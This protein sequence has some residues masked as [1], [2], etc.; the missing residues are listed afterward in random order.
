MCA[1]HR[2]ERRVLG[3]RVHDGVEG[4]QLQ[5]GQQVGRLL[6]E[7]EEVNSKKLDA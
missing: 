6:P 3:G 7:Q 4:G 1:G 2:A 5:A